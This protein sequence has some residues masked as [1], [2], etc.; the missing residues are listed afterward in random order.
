MGFYCSPSASKRRLTRLAH[1]GKTV[2]LTILCFETARNE[3]FGTQLP[4]PVFTGAI[5]ISISL[6]K[7]LQSI[8]VEPHC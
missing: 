3:A 6:R 5:S 2:I 1:D 8:R 7:H 4:A